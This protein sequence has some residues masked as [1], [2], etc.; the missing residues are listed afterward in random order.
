MD[1]CSYFIEKKALFGSYPTQDTISELLDEGVVI[2]VDLTTN[3]DKLEPYNYR[4]KEYIKFPIIDRK[5]PKKMNAYCKFIM[6]L[7]QK[8]E[9]LKDQE[10]MYIHCRGGHGRAGIVCATLLAY[11]EGISPEEACIKTSEFHKK[12]KNMKEKWRRIGSPQTKGQKR[13]VNNVFKDIYFFRAV[14]HG[15]TVGMSNFSL[16]TVTLPIY[17]EFPTV[18]SA[19]QASK[20][21]DNNDYIMKLKKSKS[22]FISRQYGKRHPK[23][24]EWQIKQYDTMLNIIR[25]KY[26]QHKELQQFLLNTGLGNI[27]HNAR[28]DEYWG[29]GKEGNGKNMLGKILMLVREELLKGK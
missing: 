20:E 10:K 17:G 12:R 15:P 8:I 26:K 1:N 24:L 16:H 7:R 25:L 29:N 14:R 11:I 4:D 27:I 3:E 21:F 23:T 18:E 28:N 22:P 19:F 5:Y 2:F 9:N 6:N 13:F